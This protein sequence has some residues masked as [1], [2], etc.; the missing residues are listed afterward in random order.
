MFTTAKIINR[1]RYVNKPITPEE[2]NELIDIIM[3]NLIKITDF[4]I[5]K[6]IP[7]TGKSY[8]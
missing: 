3:Q 8:L 7:E 4:F 1:F 2:F 6:R 5:P